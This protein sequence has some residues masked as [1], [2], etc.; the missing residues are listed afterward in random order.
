MKD[1]LHITRWTLD[2]P[3][4]EHSDDYSDNEAYGVCQSVKNTLLKNNCA[5]AIVF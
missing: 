3:V 5:S 1:E 4:D 2:D